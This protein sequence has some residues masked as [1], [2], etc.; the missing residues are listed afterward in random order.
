MPIV[1][2]QDD[3]A[4]LIDSDDDFFRLIDAVEQLLLERHSGPG[5]HTVF[6]DLPLDTE[7]NAVKV[8]GITAPGAAT[9]R[10]FPGETNEGSRADAAFIL[11]LDSVSGGLEAVLC[12]DDLNALRTSVP[13]GVG[14]RHLAPKGARVLCILGSGAQARGCARV[15]TAALPNL[16]EVVVWSPT[17]A[18][19]EA[20]AR[21]QTDKLGVAVRACETA[22]EAVRSG[23]IVMAAGMVTPGQPAFD[24]DWVKP[25]ALVI[26][27]TRSAPP[28]LVANGAR[29]V[30][31]TQNRPE[32]VAMG[33]AGKNRPSPRADQDEVVEL[34]DVITGAASAR[35]R[36]DQVVVF[37]LGN[38]YLWD[39]AVVSWAYE[40]AKANSAGQSIVLS[41][42]V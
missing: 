15:I 4:P 23:D 30:V 16:E 31:P 40:W 39:H 36:G 19:R 18:N 32:I 24:A 33:F 41:R 3:L 12:G 21:V 10:V 28:E 1:F 25:G 5:G 35:E 9:L 22:E 27:L 34:A 8:Y 6:V 38:V 11:V 37:E 2:S 29:L 17:T 13:A 14:A 42:P 20:F 7:R 26:S